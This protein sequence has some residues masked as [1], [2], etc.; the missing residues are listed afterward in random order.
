MVDALS[1]NYA[2]SHTEFEGKVYAAFAEDMQFKEQLRS[3]QSQYP[4]LSKAT[5]TFLMEDL[6][7]KVA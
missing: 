1:K 4:V 7:P 5:K 3:A 2:A 6:S